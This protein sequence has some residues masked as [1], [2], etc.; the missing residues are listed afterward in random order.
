[1]MQTIAP[2]DVR[3][4]GRR[5]PRLTH[6]CTIVG[7]TGQGRSCGMAKTT[8]ARVALQTAVHTG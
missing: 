6:A 5:P 2:H 3:G 1:M 8:P 7:D 4:Q